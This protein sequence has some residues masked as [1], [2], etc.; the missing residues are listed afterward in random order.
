MYLCVCM[1]GHSNIWSSG[2]GCFVFG[3]VLT[4]HTGQMSL[5]L[6]IHRSAFCLAR[7]VM[8]F[9]SNYLV[10]PH[11]MPFTDCQHVPNCLLPCMHIS[12]NPSHTSWSSPTMLTGTEYLPTPPPFFHTFS[13]MRS[14]KQKRSGR[15]SHNMC[16]GSICESVRGSELQH[17]WNDARMLVKTCKVLY[18]LHKRC[19]VDS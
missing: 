13:F 11:M 8:C 1:Y 16:C 17:V 18:E 15:A 7:I 10:P 9:C 4:L 12:S 2:G 14:S 6:L 3:R 19:H 5:V